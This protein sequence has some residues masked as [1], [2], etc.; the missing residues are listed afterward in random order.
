MIV[1]ALRRFIFVAIPKTGTHA[2]R[3]ALREH[4]GPDDIEQVGLFVTKRFPIPELAR[5]QHGHLS[6][7]QL[8]PHLPPGD[9]ESFFKFAFVRNPFDRFVSYCAFMTRDD[10]MF[11]RDPHLVM[12]HFLAN[13]PWDHVLFQ[14][15]HGQLVND[16]G[17]LLTDM[18]ARFETMQQSFDAIAERIGIPTMTL[19]RVNSS[20][21][22]DYRTYFNQELRDGV[23]QLYARDLEL[24]GY[25]FD[26]D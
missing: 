23:A 10:R 22:A 4:M 25:H 16:E 2:V 5:F 26:H 21:H 8:R 14:P 20:S 15:Q 6:L 9:F 24:F 7:Q 17:Q 18:I 1:S 19:K 11:E 12:R 13:P 3:H